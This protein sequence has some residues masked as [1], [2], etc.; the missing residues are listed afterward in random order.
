M[1]LVK[2]FLGNEIDAS[3]YTNGG[4]YHKVDCHSMVSGEYWSKNF[5]SRA[6]ALAYA[7]ATYK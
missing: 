5:H 7:E 4:T 2:R 3:V 1:T 6:K